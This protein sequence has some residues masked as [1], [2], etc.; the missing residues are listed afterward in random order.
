MDPSV[1]FRKKP[2]TLSTSSS[3]FLTNPVIVRTN[4]VLPALK[5][6]LYCQLLTCSCLQRACK[7]AR[8]AP[9]CFPWIIEP[10]S[11]VALGR[12]VVGVLVL[13]LLLGNGESGVLLQSIFF[14]FLASR[15]F[16]SCPRSSWI[17]VPWTFLF[18]GQ[19]CPVVSTW[20]TGSQVPSFIS[21]YM[22]AVRPLGLALKGR[23]VVPDDV[24]L[25]SSR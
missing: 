9:S 4:P 1:I 3:I 14:H 7:M 18:N 13:L 8:V 23:R 22:E 19:Q 21:C 12:P 15:R 5:P 20:S 10:G 16:T 25:I 11:V 17:W 24:M 2:F 6:F